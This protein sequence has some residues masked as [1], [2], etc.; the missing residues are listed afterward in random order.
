MSK[1]SFDLGNNQK[2]SGQIHPIFVPQPITYSVDLWHDASINW[3]LCSAFSL[4][5]GAG[6]KAGGGPQKGP[7]GA[8]VNKRKSLLMKPRHYSPSPC[9]SEGT[10]RKTWQALGTKTAPRNTDTPAGR[11]MS[12]CFV[13][14]MNNWRWI[15]KLPSVCIHI[16]VSLLLLRL[17][18]P[19]LPPSHPSLRPSREVHDR[20]FLFVFSCI[21]CPD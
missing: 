8:P 14:L 6:K 19:S 4:H 13:C 15:L 7:G 10:A 1:Q 3:P 12:C 9:P 16:V 21:R 20:R 5:L 18:S 17:L 11:Q 2:L